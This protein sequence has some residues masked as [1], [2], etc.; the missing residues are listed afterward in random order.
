ML[1]LRHA[2]FRHE[3]ASDKEEQTDTNEDRSCPEPTD[4]RFNAV[5]FHLTRIRLKLAIY[6]LPSREKSG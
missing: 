5:G 2:H 3:P 1:N 6:F 4:K